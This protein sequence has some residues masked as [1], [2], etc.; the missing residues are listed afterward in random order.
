ML[1]D[2]EISRTR[3][4]C[5]SN[6]IVDARTLRPTS[7]SPQSVVDGLTT[8]NNW[9]STFSRFTLQLTQRWNALAS[10]V[11]GRALAGYSIICSQQKAISAAH[12]H[13]LAF[14][15]YAV[16]GRKSY[17]LY[18]T[19]AKCHHHR[20]ST[21]R[22]SWPEF[23][24]D[25]SACIASIDATG[26]NFL[27]VPSMFSHDVY[28]SPA[29]EYIYLGIG[30]F[31]LHRDFGGYR[32]VLELASSQKPASMHISS[33]LTEPL[34]NELERQLPCNRAAIRSTALR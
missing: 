32:H 3:V 10:S 11:A 14:W 22:L 25:T 23:V 2:A 15:N 1:R 31:G 16:R 20:M 5:F 18:D 7:S 21:R 13:P 8:E 9:D 12:H 17:I 27:Y 34:V 6:K 28:T 4:K 24:A 29:G 19:S 30:G 33:E 26:T